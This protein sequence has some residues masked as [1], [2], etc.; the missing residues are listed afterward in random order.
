VAGIP[1]L[2]LSENEQLGRENDSLDKTGQ[3]LEMVRGTGFEPATPPSIN[4]SVSKDGTQHSTHDTPEEIL[5][6][7]VVEAWA[8]LPIELQR[9]IVTIAEQHVQLSLGRPARSRRTTTTRE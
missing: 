5:C 6:S 4:Q 1:L 9:S 8:F 7:R 3:I 2:D